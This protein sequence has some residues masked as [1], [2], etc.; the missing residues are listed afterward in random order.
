MPELIALMY[1][2]MSLR[3]QAKFSFTCKYVRDAMSFEQRRV[4]NIYRRYIPIINQVNNIEHYMI[5][6]CSSILKYNSVKVSY[7]AD[8]GIIR[9]SWSHLIVT[10]SY[11]RGLFITN[12][13]GRYRYVKIQSSGQVYVFLENAWPN[14]TSIDELEWYCEQLH[15]E[16]TYYE[17]SQLCE[18]FRV[19]RRQ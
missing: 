5:G 12:L 4:L 14:I 17:A 2:F 11:D 19:L 1:S 9:P 16:K 13:D 8:C 18:A 6:D 7:E 15:M 10:N 3:D